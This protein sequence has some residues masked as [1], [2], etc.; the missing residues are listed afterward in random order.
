MVI[1]L[2]SSKKTNGGDSTI[3]GRGIDEWYISFLTPNKLPYDHGVVLMWPIG[4][5]ITSITHVYEYVEV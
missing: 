3:T 2:Y 4:V 5:G 1:I